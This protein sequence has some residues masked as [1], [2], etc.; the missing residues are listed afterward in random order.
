MPGVGGHAPRRCARRV[1]SDIV[2]PRV[3][4]VFAAIR[5]RIEDT[6][7][8]EQLSAGVVL[9]G[10][11]VLLEGMSEFAEEVL[12]MPVRVGFPTGVQGITQLV[13]G[14]QFATATGLVKFGAHAIVEARLREMAPATSQTR[15][16]VRGGQQAPAAEPEPKRSG[17]WDWVKQAF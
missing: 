16:S 1:L 11:A 4:E 9:T 7:M 13:Q 3:E 12:G 8:L 5:K 14:P 15:L 17:F 2:E 10:G 6:G